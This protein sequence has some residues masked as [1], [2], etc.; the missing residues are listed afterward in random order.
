MKVSY[1]GLKNLIISHDIDEY[2]LIYCCQLPKAVLHDINT[3]RVTAPLY[4]ERICEYLGCSKE[5]IVSPFVYEKRAGIF[6]PW[7]Y[8]PLPK[9]RRQFANFLLASQISCSKASKVTGVVEIRIERFIKGDTLTDHEASLLRKLG[10][11]MEKYVDS[12]LD[13]VIEMRKGDAFPAPPVEPI[14]F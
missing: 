5:D 4:L 12:Y 6:M 11:E 10:G 3:S 1:L 9:F 7:C 13:M 2:D 14:D 8:D